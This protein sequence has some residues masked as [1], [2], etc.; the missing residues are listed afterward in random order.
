MKRDLNVQYKLLTAK[1][2]KKNFVKIGLSI[3]Q[4]SNTL[5][6]EK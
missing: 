6:L 3:I 5:P 4:T 2:Y 1:Y